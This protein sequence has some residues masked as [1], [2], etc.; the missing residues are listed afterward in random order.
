MEVL[1][2]VMGEVTERVASV[3]FSRGRE[4]EAVAKIVWVEIVA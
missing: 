1:L 2:K 3:A 4:F